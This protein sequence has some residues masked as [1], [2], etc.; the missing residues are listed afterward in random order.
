MHG[1]AEK[2]T[3]TPPA[4]PTQARR[5]PAPC[6]SWLRVLAQ[7]SACPFLVSHSHPSSPPHRSEQPSPA[8]R[9]PSSHS[10]DPTRSPSPHTLVHRSPPSPDAPVVHL[11]PGSTL[12]AAEQPS[13]PAT[14]PSSHASTPDLRPSPHPDFRP[15]PLADPSLP[16]WAEELT[17]ASPAVPLLEP[18]L[19]QSC[20]IRGPRRLAHSKPGSTSHVPEHPSPETSLPSSQ[21]SV[22][23]ST[24]SPH[25][26]AHSSALAAPVALVP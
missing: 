5:P 15:L 24:P 1:T 14:L 16:S 11:Y 18:N 4:S 9:F 3:L 26:F 12:H 17:W 10:S 22:L 23:A 21:A 2:H 7:R 8:A 25:I 20:G 6:L 19:A 13:P